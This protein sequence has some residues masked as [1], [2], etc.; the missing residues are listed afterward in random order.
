MT[1]S[2]LKIQAFPVPV[3]RL[4]GSENRL[5][6]EIQSAL[7]TLYIAHPGFDPD[8]VVVSE[9][10]AEMLNA[11][12]AQYPIKI[13][14]PAPE[15]PSALTEEYEARVLELEGCTLPLHEIPVNLDSELLFGL[16]E[17]FRATYAQLVKQRQEIKITR[18]FN[19]VTQKTMRV[20]IAPFPLPE[21]KDA[22]LVRTLEPISDEEMLAQFQAFLA[23]PADVTR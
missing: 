3:R 17:E 13:M 5:A 2:T 14:K 9:G 21:P 6:V 4:P 8:Y 15:M 10:G 16:S 23:Q 22:W 12:Y 18:V 1:T 19:H 20:V 7:L 11:Y